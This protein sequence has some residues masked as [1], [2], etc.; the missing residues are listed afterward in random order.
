M[1]FTICYIGHHVKYDNAVFLT[2]LTLPWN[3][4]PRIML[5]TFCDDI[6]NGSAVIMLTEHRQTS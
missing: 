5:R 3:F 1:L 4:D 6:S 2:D